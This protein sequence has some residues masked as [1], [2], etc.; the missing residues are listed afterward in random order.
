MTGKRLITVI[1][2]IVIKYITEIYYSYFS[3][4]CKLSLDIKTDSCQ[5]NK[6]C[7]Q[8]LFWLHIVWMSLKKKVL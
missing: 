6:L 3:Y 1:E 5:V 4:T 7:R 8:Q 2:V